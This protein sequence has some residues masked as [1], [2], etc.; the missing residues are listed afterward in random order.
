MTAGGLRIGFQVWG[1]YVA[2]DELM[3]IGQEIDALGFDELWSNDHLL[4]QA[5]GG[6]GAL[7]ELDGPVFEGWSIL[8]GWAGLTRQAR[9]GCLVSGAGY[10]NPGLLVKIATA[11]DHA[12]SGRAVL[13]LGAGWFER[14]HRA[15]GF[16]FPPLGRRIDRFAEAASI[17]RGLLDGGPVT[18]EGDWFT[19]R[20]AR[21]DPPPVQARLPLAIGGSGEKR[22]LRIVAQYGDIWNADGDDPA[23]FERRSTILDEHCASVGRDPASIERTAGLPPPCIRSSRDAAVAAFAATLERQAMPRS[24]ALDMA[25]RSPFVGPVDAVVEEL[26]RYRDAGLEAAMFDWPAPFDRPTLEAL[27]GPVRD[28]LAA[29]G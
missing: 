16:D 20:G 8:F 15:F 23:S 26:R 5:A 3:A 13:G 29:D 21:N 7:G 4:P 2:W 11:L 1:Q 25:S 18:A 19:M 27:A 24:A 17:C 14:E 12:T 28:A 9:M 10:R 22:T 6:A